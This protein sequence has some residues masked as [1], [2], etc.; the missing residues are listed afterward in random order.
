[1]NKKEAAALIDHT[2]LA[3]DTKRD[4]IIQMVNEA[5]E[6]GFA[7]I[8]ITPGWVGFAKQRLVNTN[9]KVITVPNWGIGGGMAVCTK[10]TEVFKEADEVDFIID[11]PTACIAQDYEKLA[12]ELAEVRLLTKNTLK[13]IV[14]CELIRKFAENN[15]RSYEEDLKNI[16]KVVEESG[17]NWIKTSSGLVPKAKIENLYED[18]D[19]LKKY[20]SL[21]IKASGGIRSLA[22]MEEC[23][24][25]GATRIGTSN[26]LYILKEIKEC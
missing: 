11:V 6:L 17:A 16:C 21:P 24:K 5:K 26:G 2:G 12:K 20:C 1:M 8:C 18:I 7:S 22:V 13:V 9:V 25:R 4:K 19:L 10:M 14:E 23:I 3:V 15:K